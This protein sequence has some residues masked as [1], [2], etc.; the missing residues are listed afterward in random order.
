VERDDALSFNRLH[1]KCCVVKHGLVSVLAIDEAEVGTTWKRMREHVLR[2][3]V[4]GD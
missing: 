4:E 2:T 1:A 3:H